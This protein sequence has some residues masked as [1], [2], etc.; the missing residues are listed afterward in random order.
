MSTKF[1]P[2]PSAA[3]APRLRLMQLMSASLRVLPLSASL[4]L[5]TDCLEVGAA[6][7]IVTELDAEVAICVAEVSP[8]SLRGGATSHDIS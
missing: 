1:P 2:F 8:C 7:L 5:L 4:I 3:A 6:V